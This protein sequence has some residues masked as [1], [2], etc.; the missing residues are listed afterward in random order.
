MLF[1]KVRDMSSYQKDC[2][3][4]VRAALLCRCPACAG[5]APFG[6]GGNNPSETTTCGA[7]SI[8]A[9]SE[10]APA[11]APGTPLVFVVPGSGVRAARGVRSGCG[12]RRGASRDGSRGGQDVPSQPV[13]AQDRPGLGLNAGRVSRALVRGTDTTLERSATRPDRALL[14]PPGSLDRLRP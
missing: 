8:K 2:F 9:R 4:G 12:Y 13:L 6:H 11:G 5:A 10:V 7:A 1:A 3:R 14:D